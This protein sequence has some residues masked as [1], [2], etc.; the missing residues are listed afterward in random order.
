MV[1][2]RYFKNQLTLYTHSKI[3]YLNTGANVHCRI[4]NQ[5]FESR[6][7]VLRHK[8][9][10]EG[11]KSIPAQPLTCFVCLKQFRTKMLLK[12]HLLDHTK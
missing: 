12:L 5:S 6:I 10:C 1:C 4:C 3:C 11:Y 7:E 2:R 8:K 9:D